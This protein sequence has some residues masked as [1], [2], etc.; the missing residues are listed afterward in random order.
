MSNTLT[1]SGL[2]SSAGLYGSCGVY[3]FDR[4]GAIFNPLD[5]NPYLLFDA[6][7]SMI[8]TL[9][10]PTLDLDPTKQ[11]SLDVITA[12]RAGTATVTDAN[13]NLATAP[14][15]TVRVD[16]VDSVPMILVEPSATNLTQR[17]EPLLSEFHTSGTNIPNGIV[18][19]EATPAYGFN[20]WIDIQTNPSGSG[21]GDAVRLRLNA[22]TSVT[23]GA[24]Y[25]FS[26]YVR[27]S[28]GSPPISISSNT[29]GDFSL[30]LG[31]QLRNTTVVHIK[32]DLYRVV[33]T[34]TYT[35]TPANIYLLKYPEQSS[36]GIKVTGFQFEAG[37][38]ATSYIPTSGSTVT[39]ASDELVISGSAFSSFFN[40]SAGTFFIQ[41]QN[42]T[43]ELNGAVLM[44][45]NSNRL[46]FYKSGPNRLSTYDGSKFTHHDGLVANQLFNA[47]VTFNTSNRSSSLDGSALDTDTI[48][49]QWSGADILKI[50]FGYS[51]NFN[52]HYRRILFWPYHSD[53]L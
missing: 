32:N 35:D 24:T 18:V 34:H 20:R 46:F 44:G 3:Q 6:E 38:V 2:Q 9:E 21:Y 45:Q 52:G 50:G 7:S 40:G 25:T 17:S 26:V 41:A 48:N 28:D 47:A 43:P 31:P 53:S 12:T 33:A 14:S 4:N 13:G 22:P 11:E 29:S 19:E 49:T 37:S 23:S 36:K 1:P 5:L 16:Y 27:T 15:D 8:G 42:K 39:R 51:N 30:L 10:N